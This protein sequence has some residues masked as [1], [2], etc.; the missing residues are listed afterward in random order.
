MNLQLVLILIFLFGVT[1]F[2]DGSMQIRK[3]RYIG[4]CTFFLILSVSLKS[5]FYGTEVGGDTLRYIDDFRSAANMSFKDIWTQF[6]D[7]YFGDSGKEYDVGFTLLQWLVSRFTDKYH[8]FST[9]VDLLF[10]IPFA[11]VLDKYCN[12]ITELF[13]AFLLYLALFHTFAMY[14]A[15]QFFA[16]GFGLM[17]FLCYTEKEYVKAFVALLLGVTIHMSL[18]LVL[19]PFAISFLQ[20]KTIRTLHV[21]SLLLV[22]VVLLFANP[23]IAFMGNVVGVE[24]YANYGSNAM[25]GG[26]ATYIILS[27]ALSV[28]CLLLTSNVLFNDAKFKYVY[29]MAPA[30][31]FFAPLIASNGSMI[32]IT[33]Y[34]QIFLTVLF[35]YLVCAKWKKVAKGYLYFFIFCLMFFIL[36]NEPLPYEFFW[37]ADPKYL[38]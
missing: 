19:V 8:I 1:L 24:R 30:F 36:K 23:I 25:Q 28:I 5:A 2:A 6:Y 20:G 34:S 38:W 29:A 4:W 14:G 12:S 21:V 11:K 13:F 10:F 9:I 26:A 22:P 37:K 35:P 33:A 15:R 17:F 18:L 3:K 32:R 27:E 31:T 7:R 16:M